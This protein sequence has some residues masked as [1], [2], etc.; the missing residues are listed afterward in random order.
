MCLKPG[1]ASHREK[2]AGPGGSRESGLQATVLEINLLRSAPQPPPHP[3]ATWVARTLLEALPIGFL[4]PAH[5]GLA[6]S[7]WGDRWVPQVQKE[8]GLTPPAREVEPAQLLA[9]AGGAAP[10]SLCGSGELV[11]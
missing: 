9:P 4:P 5:F 1:P 6:I 10:G 2:Q 7:A 3:A 11:A 8:M